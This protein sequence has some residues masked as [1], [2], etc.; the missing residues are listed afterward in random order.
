MDIYANLRKSASSARPRSVFGKHQNSIGEPKLRKEIAK[1]QSE[2]TSL[3]KSNADL[4][5][6]VSQLQEQVLVLE[7][8]I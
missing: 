7:K 2:I 5:S 6:K 4:Q 8:N 3:K 1:A